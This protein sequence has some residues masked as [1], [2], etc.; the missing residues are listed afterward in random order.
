MPKLP[1]F[2]DWTPPWGE[3]DDNFDAEKAKKLIYGLTSDKEKAADRVSA[4]NTRTKE[5]ETELAETKADLDKAEAKGN[6]QVVGELQTKVAKL[7]AD[8]KDANR[9]VL[10]QEIADEKGIPLKQAK[11]LQ[12]ETKEEIEADADDFLE[13]FGAKKNESEDED[14]ED[15]DEVLSTR[16]KPLRTPDS[17]RNTGKGGSNT[18]DL[19]A[20]PRI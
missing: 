2:E 17:S 12:G 8:L 5:L 3:D 10:V 15:E 7:T 19:D 13:T 20:V 16:P 14:D 1:K 11:R 9:K 4:A 18:I 6:E